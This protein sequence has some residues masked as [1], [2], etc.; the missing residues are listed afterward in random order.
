[1]RWQAQRDTAFRAQDVLKSRLFLLRTTANPSPSA[2]DDFSFALAGLGADKL[3]VGAHGEDA[4]GTDR[5]R[6][7]L[8]HTNGSLITTLTHPASG[9][10]NWF[11]YC[12]AAIAPDKLLGAPDDDTGATNAGAAYVFDLAGNRVATLLNPAP[13]ASDLFGASGL[14]T[15]CGSRLRTWKRRG[16]NRPR[17]APETCSVRNTS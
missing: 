2:G 9:I 16:P 8:F 6:T 15:W 13:V 1:V 7:N 14:L 11:G 5:G 10:S 12:V 17:G 4:G 3:L